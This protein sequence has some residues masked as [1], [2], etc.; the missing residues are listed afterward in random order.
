MPNS[1]LST[2]GVGWAGT[3]PGGTSNYRSVIGAWSG[4]VLNT[5]GL[6]ISGV[7]VPGAFLV[8]FGG[9]HGDYAGNELYA[10]GPLEADSPAWHR[11]TDPTIPAPVDVARLGGKPV[12]RHTYDTLVYLP[13]LNKMLCI[14]T[15]GYHNAGSTFKVS[16]VFDFGVDPTAVNAWSTND[17]GF[18]FQTGSGTI[19]LF[20]G[21]NPV[22]KKAWGLG[23]GNGNKLGSFD[24]TTGLWSTYS[25]DNPYNN[26]AA[27][28]SK[29]AIDSA[30]NIFV[31]V[32]QNGAV[33]CQNLTTPTSS[34]YAPVVTGTG[35]S[36][37]HQVLEWDVTNNRFVAW[38]RSGKTLFYL[39]VPANPASGGDSWS[40]TSDTPAGGDTPAAGVSAGTHG[41]FR[42]VGGEI[43]GVIVMPDYDEPIYFR[44]G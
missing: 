36:V 24:E 25:K 32:S 28:Y 43:P 11:I 41:R 30:H 8:L 29:G 13:N 12:S 17:T 20:S 22:T 21:F 40:W 3:S 2:S 39:N 31:W 16:D 35:P 27:P 9:G 5:A 26:T 15:A 34:I 19:G 1:T 14:G 38:E 7:F 6:Y 44:R 37:G 4:G 42:V 33:R 10:Y 18:P 23:C